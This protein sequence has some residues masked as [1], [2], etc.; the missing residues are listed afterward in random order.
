MGQRLSALSKSAPFYATW[1]PAR[2]LSSLAPGSYAEF[3]ALARHLRYAKRATNRLGRSIFHAMVRFGPALEKRQ[4]V[5]FRAVEI[6][7]E[8]YAMAA[9]CVRAQMLAK[10]GQTGGIVAR[11]G[12]LPRGAG[13]HRTQLLAAVRARRPGDLPGR[14]RGAEGAARLAGAGHRQ[15]R[16]LHRQAEAAGRGAGR[17]GRSAATR[18]AR[19]SGPPEAA[20]SCEIRKPVKPTSCEP[21]SHQH[22]SRRELA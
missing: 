4:L 11:R 19:Q 15:L 18:C 3:G 10:K 8:L 16:A 22:A 21:C 7:A 1:Y 5:L 13:P 9:A 17:H 2:W 20:A 14:V 12:V 6:G